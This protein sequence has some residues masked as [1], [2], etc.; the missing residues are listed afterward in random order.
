MKEFLFLRITASL[1]FPVI[2]K[3]FYTHQF[4]CKITRRNVKETEKKEAKSQDSHKFTSQFLLHPT[5]PC[6][7]RT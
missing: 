1:I 4:G 7:H 6:T 3:N 2:P 5:Y